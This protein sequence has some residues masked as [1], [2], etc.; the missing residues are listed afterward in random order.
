MHP[1][2]RVLD[3]STNPKLVC[4]LGLSMRTSRTPLGGPVMESLAGMYWVPP[5]GE[6]VSGWREERERERRRSGRVRLLLS[7]QHMMVFI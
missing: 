3:W 6:R 5:P 7:A 1:E 2:R 4:K